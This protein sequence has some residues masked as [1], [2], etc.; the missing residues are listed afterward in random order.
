MNTLVMQNVFSYDKRKS[1]TNLDR[2]H[3]YS[4]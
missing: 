3:V 4:K 1:V 2:T